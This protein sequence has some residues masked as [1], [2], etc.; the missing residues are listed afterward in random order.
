MVAN[1][2]DEGNA[3]DPHPC[4]S[5]GLRWVIGGY[6]ESMCADEDMCFQGKKDGDGNGVSVL[7]MDAF[8]VDDLVN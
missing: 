4:L 2:G 5:A 6:S 1:Q 7:K 3:L 8:G